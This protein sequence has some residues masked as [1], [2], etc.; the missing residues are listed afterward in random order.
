M[1][2]G[3]VISSLYTQSS[4]KRLLLLYSNY[5][6]PLEYQFPVAVT[7]DTQRQIISGLHLSLNFFVMK[8]MKFIVFIFTETNMYLCSKVKEHQRTYLHLYEG[9]GPN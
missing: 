3:I 2:P 4:I 6:I 9:Y 5:Y 7:A 1:E 8:Y